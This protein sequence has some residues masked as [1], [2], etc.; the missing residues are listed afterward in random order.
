MSAQARG[1]RAGRLTIDAS[2]RDLLNH[3]AFVGFG[4]LLLPWDDRAYDG[5]MR[6]RDTSALLPYHSQVNPGDVVAALNRMVD[7]ANSGKTIFYDFYTGTQKQQQ[8]ARGNTGLF[9]F[10][11]RPGA[12]FAVISPGGGFA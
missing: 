10:R 3:D 8:P 1:H 5:S 11:G 6:L 2:I 4:R 9:L 7:D 12:P